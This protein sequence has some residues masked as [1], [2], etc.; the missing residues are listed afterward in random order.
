MPKYSPLEENVSPTIVGTM[1]CLLSCILKYS[2]KSVYCLLLE[3]ISS[4]IWLLE[5]YY[6]D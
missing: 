4:A 3:Y 2:L 6:L 1:F 5:F